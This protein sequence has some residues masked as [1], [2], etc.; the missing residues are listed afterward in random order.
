MDNS[1]LTGE[2]TLKKLWKHMLWWAIGIFAFVIDRIAFRNP[3]LTER[4][5]SRKIYPF[6]TKIFSQLTA[7]FS[8]SLSEILIYLLICALIL[9]VFFFIRAFFRKNRLYRLLRMGIAA[10][11]LICFGYAVFIFGWGLNYARLPLGTSMELPVEN[12]TVA[13]LTSLCKTLASQANALRHQVQEDDRGV[14]IL[15]TDKEYYLTHVQELYDIYADDIMNTGGET[16]VKIAFTKNMLSATQT[17][18]IFSPFTYEC[19]INGEMPDLY[20]PSTAAHEYAH[21]KGVARED[22]ANFIAW[23]VCYRSTDADYSYSGTVLALLYAMNQLYSADYEAYAEIRAELHPGIL[24]DW[25]DDSE[26]WK[27]F[28]TDFSEQS[29]KVYNHYLKSNGISDGS[30]SYGRM[31]DLL[32]AM[33]RA[34]LLA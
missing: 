4:I 6:F 32:L 24:R 15:S 22:E 29:N 5:Y 12:S 20:V 30:K 19:H 21:F 1:K 7:H 18:G 11:T 25:K 10:V 14:F 2:K 9:F 28:Q 13:E 3:E 16:R 33:Q 34:G 17:M 27:P 23:Y 26:Y 31:L 8:I